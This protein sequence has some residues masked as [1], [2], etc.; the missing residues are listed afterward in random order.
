MSKLTVS[1]IENLVATDPVEFPVTPLIPNS[2]AGTSNTRAA[3]TAFVTSAISEAT[4][5]FPRWY[6]S[7]EPLP[8]TNIGPIW[9]DL[10]NSLM[11]WQSFTANGAAYTGY[12]SQF[13]GRVEMDTQPTARA[14]YVLCG[15]QSLSLSR[16][17][18]AALRAWGL[19]NGR[20]VASD[21][22]VAGTLLMADNPDG[23]TFR[24]FDVRGEFPRFW[25]GGR[26]IDAA[27]VFGTW[28]ANDLQSHTHGIFTR[29]QETGTGALTVGGGV[30]SGTYQTD[31]TGG[32]ETRPRNT[33]FSA[34][35][36]F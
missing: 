20:F 5:R 32:S 12:A 3:N 2:P 25:D 14:G 9:H 35:L 7:N 6:L 24:A 31:P 1:T 23:V 21:A 8:S 4:S 34:Q 36:K 33:A 10:F 29:D 22:W 18:Y 11:T 28:Q 27:R 13:V 15:S 16:T 30:S 26:G 17:Q 19:H